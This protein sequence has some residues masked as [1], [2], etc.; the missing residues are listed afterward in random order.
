VAWRTALA[1]HTRVSPHTINRRLAAVKRLVAE[2]A[3]VG[4]VDPATAEAFARITGVKVPALKARLK[5]TTRTRITPGQMRRLCEAPATTQLIGWRDRAL[6][7][8]LASSGCRVSEVVSLTRAQVL[9]RQGSFFIAVLGKNQLAPREAP[10]SQE[11]YAAIDAW[12]A[13][14]PVASAYVFTSFGGKGQRPTPRAMHIS[15]AWRVVRKYATQIGLEGMS[16][17]TFRKFV[18]T[19]VAAKHGLRAAQLTLGHKR[20]ET[21]ARFYVLEDALAG[22]LT[23]HLY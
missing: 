15:A 16:V 23:E 9:T 4:Q 18:G 8:T 1:Q 12:L 14:R 10:L 20:L 19:Q 22:G 5:P 11:A 13:R 7:H 2:A 3:L 17:H 6:L 21:T